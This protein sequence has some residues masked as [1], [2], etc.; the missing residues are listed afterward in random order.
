MNRVTVVT[1][2]VVPVGQWANRMSYGLSAKQ[3]I[4]N[5]K[6]AGKSGGS[7]ILPA[8]PAADQLAT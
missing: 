8:L 7:R 2:M 4:T 6:A 3:F 5:K 1:P